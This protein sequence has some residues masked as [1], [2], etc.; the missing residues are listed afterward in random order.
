MDDIKS[1]QDEVKENMKKEDAEKE[2]FELDEG[3][4][5]NVVSL[6]LETMRNY[7]TRTQNKRDAWL[8]Y[9]K[10]VYELTHPDD[11]NPGYEWASKMFIPKI[12]EICQ[13]IIP[14]IVTNSPRYIVY[15]LQN[16]KDADFADLWDDLLYW[17][18]K[19][20]SG[21]ELAER[22]V[23]SQIVYGTGVMRV[24][25]YLSKD[26]T[27]V[28]VDEP[29]EDEQGNVVALKKKRTTVKIKDQGW[30]GSVVDLQDFYV[31]PVKGISGKACIHRIRNVAIADVLNDKKKYGNL[32]LL[33]QRITNRNQK[34]ENT[35]ETESTVDRVELREQTSYVEMGYNGN[36]LDPTRGHLLEYWGEI[37]E[38]GVVKEYLIVIEE[39]TQTVIRYEENPY[40]AGQHRNRYERRP[41]F[42]AKNYETA[43]EEFYGIGEAELL[44]DLQNLYNSLANQ[45][46]DNVRA[47][48]DQE[49]VIKKGAM[50][51]PEEFA[52]NKGPGAVHL[53]NTNVSDILPLQKRE[54][55]SSAYNELVEA[56]RNFDTVSGVDDHTRGTSATQQGRKT[57]GEVQNRVMLANQ[58]FQLKLRH[59]ENMLTRLGVFVAN[60]NKQF[61]NMDFVFVV[62]RG[63]VSRMRQM[64]T[65]D[66]N[67]PFDLIVETGS[68][69]EED[70][71]KNSMQV[72]IL[73]SLLSN[74][75]AVELLDTKEIIKTLATKAGFENP[76][77]FFKQEILENEGKEKDAE[78]M[79]EKQMKPQLSSVEDLPP[80]LLEQIL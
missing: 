67:V 54:I 4:Q 16:K 61:V 53:I 78:K 72:E 35:K 31:D 75:S 45:R 73:F 40:T 56:Q 71:G 3:E 13:T 62:H 33:K 65:K 50:S 23:N 11:Y 30:V 10:M 46:R 59:Y 32:E 58:R 44:Y 37:E 22:F 21:D 28:V 26:S 29:V 9:H 12:F 39:T 68:T 48:M 41:F 69:R 7:E 34:N 8:N 42:S 77:R 79:I 80:E 36:K 64:T 1:L 18:W 63:G 38:D 24:D 15:P 20:T 76:K 6:V 57:L 66:L 51:N 19:K 55:P 60:M 27:S 52:K 2:A 25:W 17:Q 14:R 47:I 43:I 49:Y 70:M 74:P 5:K